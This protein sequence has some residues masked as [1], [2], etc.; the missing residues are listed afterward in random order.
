MKNDNVIA[1][2]CEEF[3]RASD[4]PQRYLAL[5]RLFASTHMDDPENP[6]FS[7]DFQF[8]I[9]FRDYATELANSGLVTIIPRQQDIQQSKST[10]LYYDFLITYKGRME[11]ARLDR[12]QKE[13][14]DRKWRWLIPLG[15]FILGSLLTAIMPRLANKLLDWWLSPE[16]HQVEVIKLPVDSVDALEK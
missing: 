11:L 10:A 1:S 15:S 14:K 5:L 12:E 16:V 9:G 3:E 8:P 6:I 7:P 4:G 13:L 2:F